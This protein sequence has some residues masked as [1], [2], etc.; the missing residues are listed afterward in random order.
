MAV[1]MGLVIEDDLWWG[2]TFYLP[3][4]AGYQSRFGPYTSVDKAEPSDGK[5]KFCFA[6]EGRGTAP[7]TE[8]EM[9]MITWFEDNEPAVSAAVKAATI[10]WCADE[11]IANFPDE[12][13]LKP[14]CGLYSVN[15]HVADGG[16]LPYIGYELGC[17]WEEEHGLGV[18]MH[19]TRLVAIGDADTA[20]HL[21]VAQKDVE[22]RRS[23]GKLAS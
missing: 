9:Q 5:T 2:A 20:L 23:I 6:P 1:S 3:S 15:I 14:N 11:Q 4:W 21:W 22:E 13:S 10:A 8:P 12:A 16:D 7:L 19:G 18:M 17:T